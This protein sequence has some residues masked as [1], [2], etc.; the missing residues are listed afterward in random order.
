MPL[1]LQAGCTQQSTSSA[2]KAPSHSVRAQPISCG[3]CPGVVDCAWADTTRVDPASARATD[4]NGLPWAV[5]KPATLHR[6]C[7]CDQW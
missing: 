2:T 1:S 7:S 3:G 5:Y 4:A 6:A